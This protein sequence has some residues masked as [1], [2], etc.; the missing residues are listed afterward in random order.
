MHYHSWHTSNQKC[1]ATAASIEPVVVLLRCAPVGTPF[2]CGAGPV[3]L[4]LRTGPGTEFTHASQVRIECVARRCSFRARFASVV[5]SAGRHTIPLQSRAR[6]GCFREPR[7][8]SLAGHPSR[9]RNRA[10]S[11]QP[12]V[13]WWTALTPA[14][15]GRVRRKTATSHRIQATL[16]HRN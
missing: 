15:G 11:H 10:Q 4:L 3:E 8:W 14:K 1:G 2:R 16:S 5:I 9:N 7:F 13:Q 6:L 12:H